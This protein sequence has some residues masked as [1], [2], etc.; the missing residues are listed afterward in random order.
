MFKNQL[1]GVTGSTV[2]LPYL[3]TLD[4]GSQMK[5]Q[6][7]NDVLTM[8]TFTANLESVAPNLQTLKLGKNDIDSIPGYDTIFP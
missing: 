8:S 3:E 7:E 1:V 6:G 4:V 2:N 5:K